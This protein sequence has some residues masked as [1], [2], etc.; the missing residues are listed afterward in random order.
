MNAAAEQALQDDERRAARESYQRTGGSKR[1]PLKSFLTAKEKREL[2]DDHAAR[3]H[4]AVAE[5]AEPGGFDAWLEA[6]E[7]NPH[8]SPMNAALVALQTPGEIVGTSASW[9]RQGYKV[10]KGERAAGR[11]T[12]PGFW[13]LAYF[14]APQ[15]AA[16]DLEG[17]E[18]TL[19]PCERVEAFRSELSALLAAGEKPRLALETV[20]KAV[21][22]DV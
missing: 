19:P 20:A 5:L 1:R 10:R 14:T 3:I 6:L 7:L 8:L 17:F 21:R 11:I 2:R 16:G 4:A 15:A 18:P 22:G 13:P 12:A 9:R